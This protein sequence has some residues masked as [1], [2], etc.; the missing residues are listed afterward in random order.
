LLKA[1]EGTPTIVYKEAFVVRPA[2]I[3]SIEQDSGSEYD[4]VK[5]KGKFFGTKKERSIWSMK[6]VIA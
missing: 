2:E 5:I 4:Q 3:H 6:K 1:P